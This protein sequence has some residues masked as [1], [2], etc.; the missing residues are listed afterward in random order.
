MAVHAMDS[1]ERAATAKAHRSVKGS[2]SGSAGAPTPRAGWRPVRQ[3]PVVQPFD[4]H[5]ARDGAVAAQDCP[6]CLPFLARRL[7]SQIDSDTTCSTSTDLPAAPED[8]RQR[9]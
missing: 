2:G 6:R 7:R 1:R 3:T 9:G 4:A 5:R 8:D